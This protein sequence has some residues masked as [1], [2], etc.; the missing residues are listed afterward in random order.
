[1]AP[2]FVTGDG[3]RFAEKAGAKFNNMDYLPAYPAA[4]RA[5]VST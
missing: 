2:S 5:T 3:Y 4:C 1:M